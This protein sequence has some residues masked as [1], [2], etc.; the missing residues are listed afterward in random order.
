[1]PVWVA[2]IAFA[3]LVAMAA[4]GSARLGT[5][6]SLVLGTY[7]VMNILYSTRLKQ[8]V[9]ADVMC[10]AIGFVLRV[11]YGVYAVG[12]LP[13]PW[14]ALCMFFLAL[15]LGFAKRKAELVGMGKNPSHARPVLAQYDVNYLNMLLAMSA[16][17]A[18]LCY[19]LFTVASH[20]NPTLVVT[21]V[22]VVYCVNRYIL[23]VM[24]NG[25][26]ESPDKILL[27]DKRLWV[28]IIGWLVAY[29]AI[30]YGNIQL[31]ADTAT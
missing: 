27:S 16:T 28:G 9:I 5:S 2:G 20:K 31:F 17:M 24:L 4:I 19:A 22:P 21:I 6:C 23:Q 1:L 10:I 14:I 29:I 25:R 12:V 30:T 7:G 15:F 26:G 3:L 11:L 13:T 18:I 8:I